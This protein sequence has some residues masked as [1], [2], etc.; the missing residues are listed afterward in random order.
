MR[1]R[2][3]LRWAI[4]V[5]FALPILMACGGAAATPTTA[6]TAT[7]ARPATLPS[8]APSATSGASGGATVVP[9]AAAASPTRAASPTAPTTYPLTIDNCG[10]KLTFAKPPE[11]VVTLAL[12]TTEIM[13]ALGLKGRLAGIVGAPAD[14]IL[15]KYRPEVAG[16]KIISEKAF[17]YPSREILLS[18]APDL[19]FSGYGGDFGKDAYGERATYQSQGA[20]TFL[21][22]G[23]CDGVPAV[24]VEDTYADI[25]TLGRIFNVPDKAAAL[26]AE[27]RAE[28]AKAPRAATNPRV[29]DFASSKADAP[30]T[31]G[32]PALLHDLIVQAGGTNI[33]ADLPQAYASVN[34][35]DVVKRDPEVIIVHEYSATPVQPVIDA[36]F[37]NPALA[38]VS[39]VKSRRV[40]ILPATDTVPSVRMGTAIAT[41][42]EAFARK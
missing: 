10:T 33:F 22:R 7:T 4:L 31:S 2:Q 18:V 27:I 11:K 5:L 36:I 1:N 41:L 40:V 23:A 38:N 35:E 12:N 30:A 39:A 37:A 19:L 26:V 8:A 28:V 13:L 21:L 9:T 20:N 32:A 25:E 42:A 3:V 34:W 16:V 24:T 29:F 6:P 14:R 15:P 17:P